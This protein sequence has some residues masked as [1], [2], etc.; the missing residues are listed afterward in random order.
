M[1]ADE[2]D[3]IRDL[4]APLATDAGAR[5]LID[6]V[7]VLEAQGEIVV[8]TDAIVEG[9]HFLAD[10]PIDT[11]AKKALRVNLSDLTAKGATCVGALVTLIWPDSRP[12][13]QIADFARGL[14]E[15][16]KLYNVPL[17][18][19]D[20]TSTP[21]PLTVS[22]TALGKPLGARVPSRAD[23][24]AGDQVWITGEIGDAW[25]GVMS[26]TETP[27]ILGAMPSDQV[28]AF[29]AFVRA[30]YRLPAPPTAFA[31]AIARFARASAD[32]SDGLCADAANIARASRVAIRIDAEALPLSA[33]G[34]AYVSQYGNDGLVRLA[35]A[36]DDY[37]ALFTAAPE[38]RGEIMSEAKRLGVAVAL[39]GDVE[40]G[41]GVRLVGAGGGEL[42]AGASGHRH[43]LGR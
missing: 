14:G 29:A 10:D 8:T 28:D 38:R 43:R 40:T 5:G 30:R 2:F 18:G 24:Q 42:T 33:P 34:H 22:V 20:T 9:V 32:V 11:V 41:A 31:E 23:A 1:S 12:A 26:L 25:L 15:D 36:G 35:T 6:D 17:L 37:Q 39:I 19:G 3:T 27:A 13:S 4:F 16:L 7:A 21:G